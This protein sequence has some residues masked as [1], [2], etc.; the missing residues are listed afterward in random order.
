MKFIIEF[1][2]DK[3]TTRII[4][5]LDPLIEGTDDFEGDPESIRL[6][7]LIKNYYR[8]ASI[9]KSAGSRANVLVR[10][11]TMAILILT[12]DLNKSRGDVADL[13]K[14]EELSTISTARTRAVKWLNEDP[15][16]KQEYSIILTLFKTKES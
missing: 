7:N 16:F 4:N 3:R 8:I 2:T 6:L 1:D 9:Q 14:Y 11:K 13:L 5:T 12:F 10:A 15:T